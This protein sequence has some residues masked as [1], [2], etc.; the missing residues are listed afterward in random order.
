MKTG[1]EHLTDDE[2]EVELTKDTLAEVRKL[3][4]E[5]YN[6]TRAAHPHMPH[7]DT[8]AGQ[9]KLERLFDILAKPF[10]NR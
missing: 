3:A 5:T 2:L 9:M 10:R 7:P 8:E 6:K 4:R 1:L